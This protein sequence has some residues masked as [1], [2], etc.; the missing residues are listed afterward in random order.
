MIYLVV[1][2]F[3]TWGMRLVGTLWL[4][5]VAYFVGVTFHFYFKNI[6]GDWANLVDLSAMNI[7]QEAILIP[8]ADEVYLSGLFLSLKHQKRNESGRSTILLHHGVLGKKENMFI[9][10]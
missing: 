7:K 10:D 6:Q 1:L 2:I 8:M 5:I 9:K 3:G 4:G